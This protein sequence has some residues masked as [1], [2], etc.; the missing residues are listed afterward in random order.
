LEKSIIK[1]FVGILGLDAVLHQNHQLMTYG[2][3]AS[4]WQGQP[5]LVLLPENAGQAAACI[6]LANQL[7]L[8]W[9]PRGSGT[10]LTGA[11]TAPNAEIVICLSR[12]NRILEMDLENRRVLVEA[13]AITQDVQNAAQKHGLTYAPDPASQKAS[14]LG[15]NIGM[16]SGGPHCLKHGITGHHVLAVELLTPNGQ[17]CWLGDPFGRQIIGPDLRGLAIGSEGCLG[18]VTRAWLRLVP[19]AEA[20]Q[21][22]LLSFPDIRSAVRAVTEIIGSGIV[23]ATLELMDPFILQAVERYKPCGYPADAGSV[24]LVEVEGLS[25]TL[26]SQMQAVLNLAKAQGCTQAQVAQDDAARSRLWEGRRGAHAAVAMIKP[27]VWVEDGTVPRTRLAEAMEALQAIGKKHDI[28]VGYVFHAGDGNFHPLMLFDDRDPAQKKK[29]QKAG[30]EMLKACV[31]LGGTITGEHGV[32]LDKI[33]FMEYLHGPQPLKLMAAIKQV[34]DP[35]NLCNPGKMIPSQYVKEVWNAGAPKNGLKQETLCLAPANQAEAVDAVKECLAQGQRVWI[36]AEGEEK[37]T[38]AVLSTR[39]LNRVV[40]VDLRNMTL[41]A[42]AGATLGQIRAL[43]AETCLALPFG[44]FGSDDWSL[45]GVLCASPG[46]LQRP[47]GCMKDWLLGLSVLLPNSEL[48]KVGRKVVKNVAGL[49]LPKLFVGSKGAYGVVLTLILQLTPRV[50]VIPA[51]WQ[52]SIE[53]S[54]GERAW[55]RALKKTLDP[56]QL[57]PPLA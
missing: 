47:R 57:F 22:A 51:D 37:S 14:T 10:N 38:W 46:S 50:S 20:C 29:V 4:N 31:D 17:L 18:L 52:A 24:L 35:R 26:E 44:D 49:D 34:F 1:Q 39:R 30:G 56:H 21:T 33:E 7:K 28:Q 5:G 19:V 41:E 11:T 13:G 45:G 40:D 2:F 25:G 32:G 48:M 53:P 36:D 55:A 8:G 3:D 54:E 6:C 9:I 23:P 12:L 42:E 15:G 27:S 16:N 43:L